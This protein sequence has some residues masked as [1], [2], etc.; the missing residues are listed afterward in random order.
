MLA[1][2]RIEALLRLIPNAPAWSIRLLVTVTTWA[3]SPV[4]RRPSFPVEA[5]TAPSTVKMAPLPALLRSTAMP[6]P[7]R[8]VNAPWVTDSGDWV[9]MPLAVVLLMLVW[10]STRLVSAGVTA[11]LSMVMPVRA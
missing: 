4:A 9:V 5:I 8:L 10:A 6:W 7:P 3:P 11:G 2:F 1:S